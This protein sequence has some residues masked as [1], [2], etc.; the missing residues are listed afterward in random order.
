LKSAIPER[1]AD[2]RQAERHAGND[3][4]EREP[5]AG[6]EEPEDVPD[7]AQGDEAV[8]ALDERASEGP[9]RVPREL[10]RLLREREA[11]DRDREQDGREQVPERQPEAGEDEPDD[12]QQRLRTVVSSAPGKN[13]TCARG[14]G[15]R[16]SLAQPRG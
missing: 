5:P 14:L 6:E 4:G 9:E 2:D 13:R 7:R 3:V 1:D 8:R 12:V 11:D 16:C 15:K 10:E